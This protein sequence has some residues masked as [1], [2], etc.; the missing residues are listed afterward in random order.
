LIPF[1]TDDPELAKKASHR[2][3]LKNQVVFKEVVPLRGNL[4]DLVHQTFRMQYMKDVVL[5]RILDEATFASL[6]SYIFYS[7]LKIVNELKKDEDFL[8][9]LFG[10]MKSSELTPVQVK[11]LLR[12]LQEMCELGKNLE[13]KSK[14]NLY[15]YVGASL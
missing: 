9:R 12:F 15:Q 13:A 2:E 7:N 3:Y 4:V 8:H 6:N 14:T 5:P 10:K 11:D 1:V